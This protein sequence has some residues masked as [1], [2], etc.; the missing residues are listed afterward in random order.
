MVVR[1]NH[2]NDIVR[3][4]HDNGSY[5]VDSIDG[6]SDGEPVSVS[7]LHVHDLTMSY[8]HTHTH[9]IVQRGTHNVIIVV[10]PHNVIIVVA[11]NDGTTCL[12][13]LDIS[14]HIHV[15]VVYRTA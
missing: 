3:S 10:A 14:S 12:A 8:S 11:P 9:T 2:D 1:S 4:N 6:Q 13:A 15:L 5:V 7:G